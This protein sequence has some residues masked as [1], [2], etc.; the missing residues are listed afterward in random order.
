MWV[1][2]C[3]CAHDKSRKNIDAIFHKGVIFLFVC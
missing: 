3:V 2:V 1:C